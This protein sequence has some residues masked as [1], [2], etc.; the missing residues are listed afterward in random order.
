MNLRFKHLGPCAWCNVGGVW[1]GANLTFSLPNS[2]RLCHL[3]LHFRPTRVCFYLMLLVYQV[4]LGDVS[5]LLIFT[6][7]I[8]GWR[9]PTA[10]AMSLPGRSHQ[11][12]LYGSGIAGSTGS[13]SSC[14]EP[15]DTD[16]HL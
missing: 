12:R 1:L 8:P 15:V 4:S 14:V 3:L 6:L 2:A 16:V 13:R 9:A 10:S 7:A 5:L 11:E